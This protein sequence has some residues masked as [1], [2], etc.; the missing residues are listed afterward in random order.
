M[1]AIAHRTTEGAII[2]V[3]YPGEHEDWQRIIAALVSNGYTKDGQSYT[4][5]ITQQ[6]AAAER[7]WLR[8]TL[9]IE[10]G[11]GQDRR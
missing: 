6:T 10:L 11:I 9:H 4:K 2:E 7:Q 1:R 8:D 5:S 3:S